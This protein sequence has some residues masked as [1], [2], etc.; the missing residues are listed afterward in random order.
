MVTFTKANTEQIFVKTCE[1]GRDKLCYDINATGWSPRRKRLAKISVW[2]YILDQATVILLE[3]NITKRHAM[4]YAFERELFPGGSKAL[5]AE[6]DVVE[7]DFDVDEC[8]N[9]WADK[10]IKMKETKP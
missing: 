3:G 5:F 2:Q 7:S 10:L 4:I 8:L 6:H 1:K 9:E